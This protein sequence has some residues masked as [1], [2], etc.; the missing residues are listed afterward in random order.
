MIKKIKEKEKRR[1]EARKGKSME[2]LKKKKRYRK[3]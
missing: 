2:G 3:C 1:R